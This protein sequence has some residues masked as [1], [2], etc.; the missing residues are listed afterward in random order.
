[1]FEGWK[2]I[3]YCFPLFHYSN[4]PFGKKSVRNHPK[5]SEQSSLRSV[6]LEEI[7]KIETMLK[8]IKS[9][10]TPTQKSTKKTTKADKTVHNE[11][12][13]H[14]RKIRTLIDKLPPR[15]RQEYFSGLLN[16]ILVDIENTSTS[17]RGKDTNK[18][19]K[20]DLVIL[21]ELSIKME[22]LYRTMDYNPYL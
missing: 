15:D 12:E 14:V 1:M 20:T 11:I 13:M 9:K 8:V 5:T 7:K 19:S 10:N 4:I 3:N 21:N 18:L 6:K 16:H 22:E 2:A 17:K